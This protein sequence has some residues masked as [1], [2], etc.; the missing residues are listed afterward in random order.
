[1]AVIG[2]SIGLGAAIALGRIAEALLFGLSGRDPMVLIGTVAATSLVVLAAG[3]LPAR[4]AA[5]VN[6]MVALRA[7]G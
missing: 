6:P 7:D 2:I 4:R 1:M 5:S 3:Y